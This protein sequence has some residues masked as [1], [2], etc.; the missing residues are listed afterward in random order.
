[1][2]D[3]Q[4]EINLAQQEIGLAHAAVTKAVCER[5]AVG[6]GSPFTA[7]SDAAVN[8]AKKSLNDA[9]VKLRR[10]YESKDDGE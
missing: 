10:L 4:N 3:V 7:R 9:E 8:A 2:A 5:R 1:M 6:R